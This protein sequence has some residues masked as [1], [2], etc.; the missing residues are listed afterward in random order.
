MDSEKLLK[1]Q[2]RAGWAAV[3]FGLI[4]AFWFLI[5]IFSTAPD[6]YAYLGLVPAIP[7]AVI[8]LLLLLRYARISK[9]LHDPGLI[10]K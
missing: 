6:G 8:S 10:R 7:S 4:A 2:K 9:K 5:A 1:S 3:I